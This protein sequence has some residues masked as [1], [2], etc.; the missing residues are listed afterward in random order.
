LGE[1]A[2]RSFDPGHVPPRRPDAT[3]WA[4]PPFRFE[5]FR[6]A[7]IAP[8]ARLGVPHLGLDTLLADLIG[9]ALA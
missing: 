5:G 1:G 8:D 6:P 9:D 7:L 3:F 4:A 2:R